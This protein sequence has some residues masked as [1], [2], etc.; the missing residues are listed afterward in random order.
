MVINGTP[1]NFGFQTT[2]GGITISGLSGVLLQSA[3]HSV[4]ADVERTRDPAGNIVTDAWYDQHVKATLE[5]VVTGTGLANAITNTALAAL[6]PGTI[7]NITACANDP[8][9]VA[10]NWEA[11][12]GAKITKSN[13][14]S[15]KISIPLEK[16]AGITGAASA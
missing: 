12:S 11:M 10:T 4:E 14:G 5:W 3:E 9:L 7:I 2:T 16:R 8:D 1:V 13:T 6:T 15:A